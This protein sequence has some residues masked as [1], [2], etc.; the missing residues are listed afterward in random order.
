M[1][2][3]PSWHSLTQLQ[4]LDGLS[5]CGWLSFSTPGGVRGLVLPPDVFGEAFVVLPPDVFGGDFPLVSTG[6][7]DGDPD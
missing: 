4:G 1:V 6:I 7:L 3:Q 2:T 5:S